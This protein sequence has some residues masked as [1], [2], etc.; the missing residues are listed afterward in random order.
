MK[1]YSIPAELLQSN[2]NYLGTR[3]YNEVANLIGQL[4]QLVDQQNK[5]QVQ[6]PNTE[7]PPNAS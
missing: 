7:Q 1:T 3:P 5:A 2:I 6:P 4:M